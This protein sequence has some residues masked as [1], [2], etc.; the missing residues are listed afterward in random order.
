[1]K[2]FSQRRGG[3][4]GER[5]Q[6]LVELAVF[7]PILIVLMLALADFARLYTTRIAVESAA[8]QAADWGAF[9]PG[10]WSADAYLNTIDGMKK[11]ACTSA[12]DLPDYVGETDN[13]ECSNPTFSCQ[14]HLPNG[15]VQ[16]CDVISTCSE[17]IGE[18]VTPCR[19]EVTLEHQFTLIAPTS[20]PLT[21]G[22]SI[23]FPSTVT[24][25]QTSIFAVWDQLAPTETA[26][27][28]TPAPPATDT[29]PP[30]P[31]DTPPPAPT[32]TPA[33]APT[34]T[35]APAPTDTPAP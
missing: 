21:G 30:A 20:I 7:A 10:N 23:G 11:R 2:F 28:E 24:F 4:D 15:T 1:M 32:D 33:P 16:P 17:Q 14:L 26:G 31:T 3:R 29:P 8:R 27:P 19:V 22:D 35:P 13:S 18:D 12:S 6:S 9:K 5:G 34:D 25:R